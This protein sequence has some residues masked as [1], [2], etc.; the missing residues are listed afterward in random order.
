MTQVRMVPWIRTFICRI[1]SISFSNKE[2]EE[3]FKN[4]IDEMYAMYGIEGGDND[5]LQ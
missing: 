2:L 1:V 3:R 5:D 4:D